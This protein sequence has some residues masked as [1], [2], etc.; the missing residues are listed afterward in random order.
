MDYRKRIGAGVR[1]LGCGCLLLLLPAIL[2]G[3]VFLIATV[4][5]ILTGD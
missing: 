4:M 3:A 1:L 2:L 5:L